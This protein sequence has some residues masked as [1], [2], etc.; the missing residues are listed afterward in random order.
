E[1][2]IGAGLLEADLPQEGQEL[3]RDASPFSQTG[4]HAVISFATR[5]ALEESHS[6]VQGKPGLTYEKGALYHEM[7][8]GI[9]FTDEQY[10]QRCAQFWQQQLSEDEQRAFRSLLASLN[11]DPH[12]ELLMINEFQAYMLTPDWE[13]SGPNILLSR[14]RRL[15]G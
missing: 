7:L 12:F 15:L 3:P 5:L 9:F 10:A 13:N 6:S 8:H 1:V 4:E 11:Y 2:L 14:G